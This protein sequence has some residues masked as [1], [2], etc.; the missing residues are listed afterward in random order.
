MKN[1]SYQKKSH[2]IFENF[3]F[4]FLSIIQLLSE[5]VSLLYLLIEKTTHWFSYVLTTF[6]HSFHKGLNI[7]FFIYSH[8]HSLP[9]CHRHTQQT[10]KKLP[11]R[12]S[13]KLLMGAFLGGGGGWKQSKG[14]K[15]FIRCMLTRWDHEIGPNM[16][17]RISHSSPL[18]KITQQI[19]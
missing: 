15:Q 9:L 17:S 7:I 19:K 5:R 2:W 6:I 12:G 10:L 18:P 16:N 8:S 4:S 3:G 11:A 1:W 13:H 14:R